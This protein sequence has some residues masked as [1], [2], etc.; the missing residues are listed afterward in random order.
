VA[1]HIFQACP[2]WIYTQSN[3]TSITTSRYVIHSLTL[4]TVEAIFHIFQGVI[5]KLRRK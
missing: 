2:V 1:R 3:I 4:F 5:C